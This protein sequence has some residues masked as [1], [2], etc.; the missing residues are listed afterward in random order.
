[1]KYKTK[2]DLSHVTSMDALL[3]EQR[4]VKQRIKVRETELR[5]KM[6]EIPAEM[7][8][9]GVNRF[10]PKIFRGKITNA[11]LNSGKKL[12]NSFI[13]PESQQ[14]PNILTQTV[15]NRGVFSILKKGIG[16]F[17]GK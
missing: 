8:A 9:A 6:Y 17:R 10:I 13:I 11:A 4:I 1:M 5:Q 3:H 16:L 7:A 2:Y 14:S 15:K 12:L